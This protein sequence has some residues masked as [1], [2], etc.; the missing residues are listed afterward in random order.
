MYP[1]RGEI[2]A[3]LLRHKIALV[4]PATERALDGFECPDES[5]LDADSA[6]AFSYALAGVLKERKLLEER[7]RR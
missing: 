2:V 5:H 4:T 1:N 3:S 7:D 6:A